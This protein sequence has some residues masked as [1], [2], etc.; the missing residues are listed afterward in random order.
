MGRSAE[1]INNLHQHYVCTLA[2]F[3]RGEKRF[4][5]QE[6]DQFWTNKKY[7]GIVEDLFP[8]LFSK[9]GETQKL[10]PNP[11]KSD[12]VKKNDVKEMHHLQFIYS[13][14]PFERLVFPL[15]AIGIFLFIFASCFWVVIGTD[16]E[17]RKS[18]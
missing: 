5:K 16:L 14:F 7:W 4:K 18:L 2:L 11:Q 10:Q 1:D 9:Q 8:D 15:L 17:D 3:E 13:K 12:P 6:K